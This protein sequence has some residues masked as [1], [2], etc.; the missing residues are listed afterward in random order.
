MPTLKALGGRGES[1][2]SPRV[3]PVPELEMSRKA[4]DATGE[5]L[6]G[7]CVVEVDGGA[8]MVFCMEA[9]AVLL[10][11]LAADGDAAMVVSMEAE[12]VLLRFLAAEMVRED[13]L[14]EARKGTGGEKSRGG[15]IEP[16]MKRGCSAI[17]VLVT[18][19]IVES[20][21]YSR[22]FPGTGAFR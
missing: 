19:G 9:E 8:A 13:M 10:G 3:R 6:R 20:I 2:R 4:V 16:A 5:V 14:R 18:R 15:H 7:G 21:L 12:A 17:S 1:G 11:F 22:N